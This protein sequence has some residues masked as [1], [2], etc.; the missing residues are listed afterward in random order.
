MSTDRQRPK[1]DTALELD[2]TPDDPYLAAEESLAVRAMVDRYH[3]SGAETL[4][5]FACGYGYVAERLAPVLDQV[6][7]WITFRRRWSPW[8]RIRHPD[9]HASNHQ[10]RSSP[11]WT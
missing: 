5:N 10:T 2:E 7:I 3:L 6:S 11:A 8:S 9:V 1:T 4:P